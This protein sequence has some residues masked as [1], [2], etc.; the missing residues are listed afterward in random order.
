MTM[1]MTMTTISIG[2][3]IVMA[4]GAFLVL[5]AIFIMNNPLIGF[6]VLIMGF[7]AIIRGYGM[8]Q[9]PPA[10]ISTGGGA[11]G[12]SHYDT[13]L[14]SKKKDPTSKGAV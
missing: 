14:S 9:G 4:F 8:K 3:K 10:P 11:P 1:T 13:G 12:K 7:V 5:G 2:G 6:V